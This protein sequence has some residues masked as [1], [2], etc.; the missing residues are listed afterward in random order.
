[1]PSVTTSDVIP[2]PEVGLY[3]YW[4]YRVATYQSA[5]VITVA[6]I[7]EFDISMNRSEA[8]GDAYT[9]INIVQYLVRIM[10]VVYNEGASQSIAVLHRKV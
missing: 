6:S 10:R 1:M 7:C 2:V 4:H 3:K 5:S 8:G 9:I